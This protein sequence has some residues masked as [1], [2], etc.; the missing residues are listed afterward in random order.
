MK[1]G[2]KYLIK[3]VQ[4]FNFKT[5]RLYTKDNPIPKYILSKSLRSEL[6]NRDLLQNGLETQIYLKTNFARDQ[7]RHEQLWI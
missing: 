2:P 5:T 4:E 1:N 6:C 7:R 3:K